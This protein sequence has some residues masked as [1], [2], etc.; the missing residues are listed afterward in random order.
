MNNTINIARFN[1]S[2]FNKNSTAEV[3]RQS[4]N[5]IKLIK[6]GKKLVLTALAIG[7]TFTNGNHAF[8]AVLSSI[9]SAHKL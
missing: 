4:A 3:T 7:I 1:V 9:L 5:T 2:T 8:D 6:A